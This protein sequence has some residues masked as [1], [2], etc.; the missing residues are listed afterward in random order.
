MAA[1]AVV[2][3]IQWAVSET[4]SWIDYYWN[5]ELS[6]TDD[7]IGQRN[8][9]IATTQINRVISYAGT[10]AATTQLGA[11]I[12]GPIGAAIGF[13]VGVG[14]DVATVFRSNKQGQEQQDILLA[15]MNASLSFTRARVGWS[16]TAAS[17]GED[18]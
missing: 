18:L 7:Y 11:S 17:I 15:Q 4:T 3:C 8:K 10:A 5:Q 12:G 13:V 6:L 9:A 14:M 2:R 16:T 1:I